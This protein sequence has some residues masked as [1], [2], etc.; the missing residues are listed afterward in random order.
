MCRTAQGVS[1]NCSGLLHHHGHRPAHCRTGYGGALLC[2]SWS[3]CIHVHCCRSTLCAI[4][5]VD[6]QLVHTPV[7]SAK[8]TP[9]ASNTMHNTT[10]KQHHAQH[11][12]ARQRCAPCTC[13]SICTAV[14]RVRPALAGEGRYFVR[15]PEGTNR[16]RA[17]MEELDEYEE[18]E[19]IEK[20]T[21]R[22]CL[23][24]LK[25]DASP[26]ICRAL[27]GRVHC[28]ALCIEAHQH[29]ALP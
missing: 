7:C 4:C 24:A 22:G 18:H 29:R 27:R 12:C 3:S 23:Y 5:T 10:C 17:D 15:V 8:A 6:A 25:T 14:V 28:V 16:W 21:P 19:W 26:R 20:R 9:C 2:L 1:A 13:T 11:Q